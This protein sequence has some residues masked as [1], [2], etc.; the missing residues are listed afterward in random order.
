M[1]VHLI[2]YIGVVVA[3]ALLPGPD[4]AVVTKN[5]L[6]HGRDAALGSAIG[7]NVGL[8]V[9]TV[10]TALGVAAILRGSA[11]VYDAL[12]LIGA[13]YLIWIGARTLWDS[14]RSRRGAT[15]GAAGGRTIDGRGGFLQGVISNLANPKVGIFFTSLLPQFV[16]PHGSALLQMLMLGGIFIAFNVFW[17]CSY[18][19][20]AVRLSHVLSRARVKAAIDRVSGLALVGVGIRLAI[21]R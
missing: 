8:A 1:P 11:T 13:L 6:I 21:E 3:I 4:T 2:V 17:M 7:V 19:V 16:S 5:A 15:T 20:A 12:K 10:A 18:A 14:R 9:W